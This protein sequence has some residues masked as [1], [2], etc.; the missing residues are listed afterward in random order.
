M[1]GHVFTLPYGNETSVEVRGS[2]G[3]PATWST[4]V[5]MVHSGANWTATV[6]ILW[7]Q[8][9]QYKFFKNGTTWFVDPGNPNTFI[10]SMNNVNSLLSAPTCAQGVCP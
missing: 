7:T 1:C 9:T 5:M 8:P 6:N 4:G 10:D 2:W 3:A